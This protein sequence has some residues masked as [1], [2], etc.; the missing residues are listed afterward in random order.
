IVAADRRILLVKRG[1]KPYKGKWCLPTG[2]AESG[3]SIE[4]AALRELEEEA[5]IKGRVA[6][7]VDVDSNRNY[8]YGDLLFIA[9]EVEQTDGQIRAGSDTTDV[10]YFPA[11]ALP[12]L[13]FAAN[14]KAIGAYV[15]G[16][17]ESWAIFDSFTLAVSKD[18][19]YRKGMNLLSDRLVDVIEKDAE[20]IAWNWIRDVQTNRS[21]VGYR[22]AA[23]EVLFER[24]HVILSQFGK[25]LRG[26]YSEKEFRDFY[27][28]EGREKCADGF[29]LS[30][31]LGAISLVRKHIWDFAL[32]RSVWHKTLDIY[33]VV[34][35]ESRIVIFFDKAALYTTRGYEQYENPAEPGR[36]AGR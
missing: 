27:M 26:F 1:R 16:K 19:A 20:Q 25:W 8:L 7:L 6:S 36:R 2:F 22:Q 33:M 4:E 31:V 21:T 10:R 24:V 23:P 30:E 35:L 3:E 34:E 15:R 17:A 12:K 14:G 28:E 5:G 9:F 13:A 32:S 11:E 29:K 18:Q